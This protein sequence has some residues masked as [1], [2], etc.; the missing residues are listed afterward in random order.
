MQVTLGTTKIIFSSLHHDQVFHI[1][2]DDFIFTPFISIDP[3]VKTSQGSFAAGKLFDDDFEL[4]LYTLINHTETDQGTGSNENE[5]I[6]TQFL[7][8]PYLAVYPYVSQDSYFE[9]YA[10]VAYQ[11][12]DLKYIT[13]GAHDD[14][15]DQLGL[16]LN[17]SLQY[18]T[19]LSDKI[20]FAPNVSLTYFTTS[21][22]GGQNTTRNGYELQ[23]LPISFQM[24]L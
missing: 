2:V 13:N 18:S 17:F 23:I 15:S 6:A 16:N 22:F 12:N 14:V 9:I 8:G 4:G 11:Y 20:Y 7:L 5:I 24:A 1:N 10:R 19:K 3:T 21:D